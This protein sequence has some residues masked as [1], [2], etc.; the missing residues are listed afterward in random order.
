MHMPALSPAHY[1]STFESTAAPIL[2]LMEVLKDDEPRLIR[3]RAEF[4]ALI[5][6]YLKDNVVSQHFLMTR[7]VKR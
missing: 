5:K 4:D 1:R 7:A 2:K 6:L 3:F